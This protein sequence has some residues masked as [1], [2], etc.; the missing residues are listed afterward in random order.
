[1][2]CADL[3]PRS[4]DAALQERECG[5]DCVGCDAR[6]VLIAHVFASYMVD[7]FVLGFSD[8]VLVGGEAVG[9]EHFNIG[10]HVLSNVFCQRAA[11]GIFGMEETQITVPLAK[12]DDYFFVGESGTLTA[13]TIFPADIGF[14]HFDSTVKHGLICFFH[15]RTDAVTEVPCGFI[16]TFVL[17][18]DRALKL[19]GTHAFLS[20][21][22]Q[23]H[24]HKPKRQS[25]MGIVENRASGHGEL[26]TAFAA[27]E[28]LAGVNPPHV[29][30]FATRAF[31]AFGPSKPGENL[32]AIFVSRELF[33][34]FRECHDR[35]S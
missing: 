22:E 28:L 12:A 14:V 35:T 7:C 33:V 5:F 2:L 26:V 30:V 6:A 9:N 17:A 25:Q 19:A 1:M 21:T 31:H 16:G 20:F 4:H 13:P 34:Q 8:S 18:P 11:L 3:V 29:A 15:G 24:S 23:Q 10:A 27:R 32:T